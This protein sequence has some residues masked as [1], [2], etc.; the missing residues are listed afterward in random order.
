VTFSIISNHWHYVGFW[1]FAAFAATQH[2]GRDWT[3]TDKG[4][5]RPAMARDGEAVIEPKLPAGLTP[6]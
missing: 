1:H 3:T 2:L 6:H 4:R 5:F